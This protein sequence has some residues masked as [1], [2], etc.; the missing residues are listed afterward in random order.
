MENQTED[1]QQQNSAYSQMRAAY[2]AHPK[3]AATAPILNIVTNSA[4]GPLHIRIFLRGSIAIEGPSL[5]P[6]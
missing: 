4:G 3:T 6:H 2:A 1:S 5:A